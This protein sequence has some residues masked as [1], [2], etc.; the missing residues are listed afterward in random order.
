MN[1]EYRGGNGRLLAR[2][3]E[4]F[5]L[6][7]A[8]LDRRGQ[9]VFVNAALC[10]IAK[11]ASTALVGQRCSWKVAEDGPAAAIL[12]A[13][14]PPPS[15]LEGRVVVRQ[16][17]VPI[18]YGASETGQLFLPLTDRSGVV[19][20]TLVLLGQFEQI[21]KMFPAEHRSSRARTIPDRVLVH[22]RSRWKTLDGLL[23]L[24]GSSP[25]IELALWRAQLAISNPCNILISGPPGTGKLEVAQ[26]AFLGRMK[27][28]GLQAAS[29]QFFPLDCRV[30]DA[31][32]IDGMLE[33]FSARLQSDQPQTAQQLVLI[34]V[35]RLSESALERLLTWVEHHHDECWMSAT[36]TI[37]AN[38]LVARSSQWSSL[39]NRLAAI[40]IHLPRL[41]DRREDISALALH[42]LS[43]ECLQA[44]RAQLSLSSDA[45]DRLVA[46]S[47]PGNVREL[48]NAIQHAVKQAVL[49]NAVHSSHLP[50]AIRAFP[51]AAVANQPTSVSPID[52]DAV[53]LDVEKT[54]LSRALR[55]S[56]RNRAGAA[57]LLGISR[58][59]LLRR[60]QQLGLDSSQEAIDREK[61]PEEA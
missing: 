5:E 19:E 49:T 37:T 31:E 30:L 13:L 8:I 14:A 28:A 12:T 3:L 52:L 22:L 46:Y 38:Q 26:G 35:D 17:T 58:P 21:Q 54:L 56:P 42:S 45:T 6:P 9:I 41:A 61:D 25:A 44:D 36:S 15:A 43:E 50:V 48:R 4:Q 32:L 55:F 34:G 27:A 2:L 33:I 51:S 20:I 16:L 47:W 60:I 11:M 10:R 29:G 40:E 1:E 59:R 18:V 23:S 24:I 7:A 39:I 53:L 57:R